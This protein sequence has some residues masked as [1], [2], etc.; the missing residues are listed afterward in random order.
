MDALGFIQ[1]WGVTPAINVFKGVDNIDVNK[2]NEEI[3]ILFSECGGD[4]RDLFKTIGDLAIEVDDPRDQPI[5]IYIHE[6]KKEN[7]ARVILFLTLFCETGMSIRER[8][9]IFLD[10]YGNS[11]L[12]D[13]SS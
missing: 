4:G 9:E 3:N 5:N 11:L 2:S 8:M 13:R 7:L 1:F 6:K 12:R 10:I